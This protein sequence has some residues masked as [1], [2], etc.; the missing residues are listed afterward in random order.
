LDGPLRVTPDR[1]RYHWQGRHPRDVHLTITINRASGTVQ[2][3]VMT[4]S[5]RAGWG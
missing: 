3:A 4:V 2:R 5:L 1:G